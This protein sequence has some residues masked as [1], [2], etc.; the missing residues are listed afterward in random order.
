MRIY[1]AME[2]TG[3]G[4]YGGEAEQVAAYLDSLEKAIEYTITHR[5]ARS[6]RVGRMD[7]AG[8]RKEALKY[9]KEIEVI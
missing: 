8:Q 4:C 2:K 3:Y 9:I 1:A 5:L 7:A 6:L